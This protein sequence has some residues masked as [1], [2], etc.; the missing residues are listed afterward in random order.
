MIPDYDLYVVDKTNLRDIS[1]RELKSINKQNEFKK[2]TRVKKILKKTTH[3][4]D[5]ARITV[6][7][8]LFL[9]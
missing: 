6:G 2:F 7:V 4:Y 5:A 3:L 8:L 1:P 9:L